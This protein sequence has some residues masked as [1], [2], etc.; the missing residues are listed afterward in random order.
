MA[1]SA[2]MGGAG[3]STHQHQLALG[4]WPERLVGI[5]TDSAFAD[6]DGPDRMGPVGEA[7]RRARTQVLHDITADAARFPG[8]PMPLSQAWGRCWLCLSFLQA[9]VQGAG[10]LRHA[11]RAFD[12]AEIAQ[13]EE[14]VHTWR[15]PWSDHA[16]L[17][18]SYWNEAI[19]RAASSH[20]LEQV[21][22]QM[23]ET[24]SGAIAARDPYTVDHQRR[25]ADISCASPGG[26]GLGRS[27]LSRVLA[28]IVHDIGKIQVPID[29]LTKPTP[30][31]LKKWPS[32][33]STRKAPSTF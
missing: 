4:P 23:I 8:L 18:Q 24:L 28:A 9:R 27:A 14:A 11:A 19:Q 17:R 32:Y 16:R 21:L 1:A 31:A 13:L 5:S 33:G 15:P 20:R 22:E 10:C 12:P 7:V 2:G 26:M 29:L 3:S 25:V 30:C 6:S